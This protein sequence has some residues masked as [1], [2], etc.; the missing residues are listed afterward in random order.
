MTENWWT[1]EHLCGGDASALAEER[2]NLWLTALLL[3][4]PEV[5]EI[6]CHVCGNTSTSLFE[7]EFRLLRRSRQ[8]TYRTKHAEAG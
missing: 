5:F 8:E 2:E 3:R 4:V 7:R 1:A 6:Q